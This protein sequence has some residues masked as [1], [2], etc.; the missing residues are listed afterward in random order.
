MNTCAF[1]PKKKKTKGP[2]KKKRGGKRRRKKKKSQSYYKPNLF[3]EMR[4]DIALHMRRNRVIL[5]RK[6][7]RKDKKL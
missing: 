7:K 2:L 5:F 6:K 4:E 3:N 1:G